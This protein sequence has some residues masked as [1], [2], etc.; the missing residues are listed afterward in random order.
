MRLRLALL[1]V[2]LLLVAPA[3]TRGAMLAAQD[4]SPYVPL[5][6][7]AMPYVEHLI[8]VG[9]MRDPAP[10]TRPLTRAGLLRAL[11]AV[12]TARVSPAVSGTLRRLLAAFDAAPP[13]P[14]YRLAGD[15]GVGAATY[16]RRDA[17]AAVDA[18]GPRSAGPK[19]ATASGGVDLELLL[20]PVMAVTHPYFDT[21]LKYDPDWFGKKDRFVAGRTAESYVAAQWRFGELLFGR[22]DRNWG[23]SA[24][25]GLLLSANPYGLDHLA[26]ALGTPNLQIQAIATQLDDGADSGVVAHRYMEQHRVWVRPSNRW[27]VAL[28]EGS[29]LSGRDRQ[30]EPWYLNVMNLGLLEQ[31]NT[32]TNVNTFVG[33]DIERRGAFTLFG[34]FM[35][36]DIQV[37]RKTATDQKPSSYAL[38]VGG[39]GGFGTGSLGWTLFYTRVTNLTYRNEDSL[40]VPLFHSLGTGR[41]FA[42]YDQVTLKLGLVP[43]PV[44]LLEPEVTLL[45]QGEG[46]PRL[47]HPPVAAYPTTATIF[48]GVV[49]RT[50]RLALGAGWQGGAWGLSGNG[51]VHFIHNAGHVTGASQTKWIGAL[52]LAYRFHLEGVLP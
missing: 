26:V 39:K 50:V 24:L 22:L 27:A 2:T 47:P 44:L 38:T 28:W 40:Q 4:A 10:L 18:N 41:N 35:L 45:R 8:T 43:R 14:R 33:L 20:G 32:G 16:T 9:V 5:G 17:L 48:A 46:D 7:W 23:P 11:R 21:R 29:V 49:E 36:D 15:I 34:Q 1:V 31:L 30:F 19:H 51:G 12:D 37:D 3:L 25:Q 13:A 52:T 6:H 42:D